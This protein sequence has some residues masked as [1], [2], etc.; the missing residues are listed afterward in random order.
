[1]ERAVGNIEKLESFKL[2]K[3]RNENGKNEV[4]KFGPKFENIIEVEKFSIQ[5]ERTI[6]VK[7]FPLELESFYWG[8]KGQYKLSIF[9]RKK[10]S[11]K[12]FLILKV[13][14]HPVFGPKFGTSNDHM[15]RGS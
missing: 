4:G 3:V 15:V 8:W 1:M 9:R 10:V 11:N 7:K 6:V 2:K 14:E 5:L 12:T 13:A